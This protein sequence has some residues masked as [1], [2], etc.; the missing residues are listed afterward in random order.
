MRGGDGDSVDVIVISEELR[1]IRTCLNRGKLQNYS[2]E[3]I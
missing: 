1:S 3:Q 2:E